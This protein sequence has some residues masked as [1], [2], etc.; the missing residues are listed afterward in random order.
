MDEKTF[1]TLEYHKIL[2]RLALYA[3]FSASAELARS[4]RPITD[5]DAVLKRQACTSEARRL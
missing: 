1:V 4:L 3:S 5:L 2:E